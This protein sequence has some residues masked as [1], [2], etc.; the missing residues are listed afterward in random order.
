MSQQ[1]LR[2]SKDRRL[3]LKPNSFSDGRRTDAWDSSQLGLEPNSFSV[4]RGTD[5]CDLSRIGIEPNSFT[6]GLWTDVW[7][8]SQ[9]GLE[10]INSFGHILCKEVLCLTVLVTRELTPVTVLLNYHFPTS[11][12]PT[13]SFPRVFQGG[14]KI[15]SVASWRHHTF[16]LR[17]PPSY[18]LYLAIT[19]N[20][21]LSTTHCSTVACR[22]SM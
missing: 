21:G 17:P 19:S 12:P 14:P 18:P 11:L 20:K 10:S 15:F 22:R 1:F 16:I 4:G 8:S 2:Q 3:G 9:L 7:D 13:F 6:V 5:A